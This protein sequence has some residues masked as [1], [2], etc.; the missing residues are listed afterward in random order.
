LRVSLDE[1]RQHFR[2]ID[3]VLGPLPRA[4]TDA[5]VRAA[6]AAGLANIDLNRLE[7]HVWA[8][9]EGNPFV[10]LETVLATVQ[11]ATPD[12]PPTLSVPKRVR[13]L[14]A[15]R[16]ARVSER[17]RHVVAVA[18]VI[19]REFDVA[20]VRQAGGLGDRETAEAVEEL[21]RR[22][23]FRAVGELLD[24]VHDRIREVAVA[25]LAPAQRRAL[26]RVVARAIEEAYGVRLDDH[27]TS[28]A[29]HYQQGE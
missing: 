14:V 28:L 16:L 4:D 12:A 24:F 17:C 6:A 20:V 11:S 23:L 8:L 18:S 29:V 25:N 5:L 22:R 27:Y 10:A 7:D 26:H 15:S 21:V 2:F 13:E 3:L 1:L 19:G 9:S